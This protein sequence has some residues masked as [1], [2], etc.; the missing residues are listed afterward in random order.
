ME[1]LPWQCRI[2][3]LQEALY[4][5]RYK[6]IDTRSAWGRNRI[7]CAGL[8]LSDTMLRGRRMLNEL[9]WPSG[10]KT[11]TRRYGCRHRFSQMA[12]SATTAT[13]ERDF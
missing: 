3:G 2:H 6:Y 10:E 9:E 4:M 13:A 8:R 11:D 5:V 7:Q 1:E 12:L